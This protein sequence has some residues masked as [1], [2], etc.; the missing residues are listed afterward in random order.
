MRINPTRLR[1]ERAVF[2]FRFLSFHLD[3]IAHLDSG[4]TVEPPVRGTLNRFKLLVKTFLAWRW[5]VCGGRVVV[6]VLLAALAWW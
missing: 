1:F 3:T 5:V 6:V 2:S 4:G